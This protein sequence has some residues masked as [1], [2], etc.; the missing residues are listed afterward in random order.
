M[1]DHSSVM[2]Y[3]DNPVAQ[4]QLNRCATRV[5]QCS[6]IQEFI[7]STHA[8]KVSIFHVP[9]PY[10]TSEGLLFEQR[11]DQV[12]EY[13]DQIIVIVSELHNVTVDFLL[14]YNSPKTKYFVCGVVDELDT[15]PWMDWFT[16]TT[17]FYKTSNLKVLDQLAPFEPKPKMF[18][19]LLGMPKPHRD[20]LNN[21]ILDNQLDN[22]VILTY[23]GHPRSIVAGQDTSGW[24]WPAEG[25]EIIDTD[26]RWTVGQVKY[27]GEQ[28]SLS[29]VVP[30]NIYQQTAYSVV[31]ETNYANHY[32][33]YTEKIVK[34]MLAR[35]LFLVFSGQYYLRNLRSLG[36]RT[37]DGIIDESYDTVLDMNLRGKLIT[38]QMEYLLAQDQREV[39][40]AVRPIVE[41]NYQ[42]L[43]ETDWARQMANQLTEL[44]VSK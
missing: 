33:F 7:Q 34:P 4:W 14:R 36:F 5:N 2:V 37:F 41:H 42:V 3:C 30:I 19:I 12:E 9:F 24:V 32:S 20:I 11:I 40:N 15:L 16:T 31:A 44:I 27:H 39:L 13:S 35:R 10:E 22:Q 26:L 18:D 38:N 23:L 8:R 25:L 1:I 29:Q 17:H 28:M 43:M 21:Y 6:D